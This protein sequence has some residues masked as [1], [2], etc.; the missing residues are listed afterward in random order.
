MDLRQHLA[1]ANLVSGGGHAQVDIFEIGA[2][3]FRR[4]GQA[5]RLRIGRL[6]QRQVMERGRDVLPG[7]IQDARHRLQAVAVVPDQ[8]ANVEDALDVILGVEPRLAGRARGREQPVLLFPEADG[9]LAE[10]R[11][12]GLPR[13][14]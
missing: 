5:A 10:P 6:A 1:F 4:A 12:A 8:F 14:S 2:Q 7:L 11:C 3:F 9:R 13:R